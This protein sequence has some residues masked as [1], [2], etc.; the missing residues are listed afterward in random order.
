MG[1]QI[2]YSLEDIR[3]MHSNATGPNKGP[4]TPAKNTDN[5]PQIPAKLI[6]RINTTINQY[7]NTINAA[8]FICIAIA[9]I[10]I[11]RRSLK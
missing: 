9:T 5:K 8:C 7:S 11:A 4:E 1:N 10:V 3:A 6:D 2:T